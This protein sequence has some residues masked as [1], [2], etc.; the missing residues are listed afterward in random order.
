[1]SH[2]VRGKLLRKSYLNLESSEA[3]FREA[4]WVMHEIYAEAVHYCQR[5]IE[6]V[7]LSNNGMFKNT[8]NGDMAPARAATNLRLRAQI[9][10]VPSH[11]KLSSHTDHICTVKNGAQHTT[12]A[13]KITKVIFTVRSLARV[14][15]VKLLTEVF[16]ISPF[17]LT[18][19]I[20][21]VLFWVLYFMFNQMDRQ[22]KP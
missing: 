12:Y 10:H 4:P 6:E 17:L 5:I 20:A 22:M 18:S 8:M 7:D 9:Q 14:M 15:V 16:P 19:A 13:S 2:Y 1:M 21:I 3:D 11:E